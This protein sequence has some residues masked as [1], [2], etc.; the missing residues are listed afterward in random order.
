MAVF[1]EENK[2][3]IWTAVHTTPA[4]E[5]RF[6]APPPDADA[7]GVSGID[8]MLTSSGILAEFFRRRALARR[9]GTAAALRDD[10]STSLTRSELADIVWRLLFVD[11]AP[12]S[13]P[14]RL[15][16]T[17]LGL[18]GL[19]AGAADL[20]RYREAFAA[21]PAA[22]RVTKALGLANLDLVLYPV[23][24]MAAED[25][26]ALPVRTPVFR[27][28]LS[29]NALLGNWKHSARQLRLRGYGL[30]ARI[31]E[32]TPLELRRHL[33]AAVGRVKP[34]ALALEWPAG[35][36]PE[37]GGIGRLVRE[38]VLP[39]CRERGLGILLTAG[40]AV[41][42]AD[43]AV[44]WRDFSDI[45][46]LL[47]PG[48]EDHLAPAL[49]EAA[50]HRNLLLGSPAGARATPAVLEPF[51]ARRLEAL[52]SAFH[53]CD[54]GAEIVEELVGGWAHCR[55][56]LGQCL[57]E[58][59]AALWRTGWHYHQDAIT[60]DVTALLGGNLRAFLGIP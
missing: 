7:A 40:E 21:I 46:F 8:A 37:D 45:R 11:N 17:T 39:L 56:T 30:K 12:L 36:R 20:H 43:L 59:Y 47:F 53:A 60:R 35:H 57:I 41:A 51:L 4:A 31:D 26:V 27:P 22:E 48:R 15:V 55:W 32:F 10:Y 5:V 9:D 18:Y 28:V 25:A 14:C 2:H 1:T 13:E 33:A 16:L 42:V 44:L 50:R 23:D 6:A 52:G 24:S 38:A 49:S 58:R 54:T 34:T 19:D 3:G 29:L